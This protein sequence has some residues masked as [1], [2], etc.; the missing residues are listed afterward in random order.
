MEKI[1]KYY[2]P[3]LICLITLFGLEL[4]V[5]ISNCP[6]WYDEGHSILVAIQQFPFGIDNF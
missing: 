5:A 1:R 6:M 2:V 3:I 4:R